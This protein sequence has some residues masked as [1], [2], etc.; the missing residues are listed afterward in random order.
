MRPSAL[1]IGRGVT[2]KSAVEYMLY[3][4]NMFAQVSDGS[5]LRAVSQTFSPETKRFDCFQNWTSAASRLYQPLPTM[6]CS[7]GGVPVNM[8]D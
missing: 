3:H 2:E 1:Y 7:R 4:Q 6:P 8:L 5:R